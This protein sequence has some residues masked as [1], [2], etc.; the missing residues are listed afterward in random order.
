[1][2]L[3]NPQ[4]PQPYGP[5]Q[6]FQQAPAPVQQPSYTATPPNPAASYEKKSGRPWV[7]ISLL[8]IFILGFLGASGFGFWA[9]AQMNDYKNNVEEKVEAAVK[10]AK[11]EEGQ[12]KEQEF[13]ERSKS[14]YKKYSGPS[15]FGSVEVTYPKTW[16]ATV[17]ETKSGTPVS[18]YFHPDFV[19]GFDS[20]TAFALRVEVIQQ[21]YDRVMDGF[22]SMVKKGTVRVSPYSAKRVPGVVGSRADGE[23]LRGVNGSAVIFPLRDKTIKVSTLSR[24][25]I[26]DFDNIILPNLL[27]VP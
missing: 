3:M 13:L 19:P 7:L 14:P 15:T 5:P 9:F 1:M 10:I 16:S 26:K 24:S 23:I 8:I 17:A 18:G 22:A 4:S 20:G 27:F 6:G 2:S 11:E 25:F 21:P 12:V